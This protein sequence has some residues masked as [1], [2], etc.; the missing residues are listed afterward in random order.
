MFNLEELYKIII[1][2][3][4]QKNQQGFLRM[5]GFFQNDAEMSVVI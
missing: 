1:G 5:Q 4:K 2:Q 3:N